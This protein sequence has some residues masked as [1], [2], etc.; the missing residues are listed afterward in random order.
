MPLGERQDL[1]EIHTVALYMKQA[2][3]EASSQSE[4]D[5]TQFVFEGELLALLAL[6]YPKPNDRNQVTPAP[7]KNSFD[8]G[9]SNF[10]FA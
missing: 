4:A 1:L 8:R 2:A 7:L 5:C 10:R 3:N 9:R 6:E